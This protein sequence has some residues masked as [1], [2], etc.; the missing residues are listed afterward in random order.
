MHAVEP[1]TSKEC[2]L[3]AKVTGVMSEEEVI[4]SKEALLGINV[5]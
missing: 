2:V 1:S 4:E 3:N 5:S